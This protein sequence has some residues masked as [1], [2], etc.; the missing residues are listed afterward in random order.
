M[1]EAAGRQLGCEP[2]CLKVHYSMPSMRTERIF[3]LEN[4]SVNTVIE[5]FIIFCWN[6]V[7]KSNCRV[8]QAPP[9]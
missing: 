6:V 4:W 2:T 7:G 3:E 1:T 5:G 8:F 9:R